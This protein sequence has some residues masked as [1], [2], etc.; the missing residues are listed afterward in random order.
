MNRRV[1]QFQNPI[2]LLNKLCII[3]PCMKT[4]SYFFVILFLWC[5]ALPAL[6]QTHT[7]R[8]IS[9][10]SKT[11]A[12]YEYLPEGYDSTG[13]ATYPLILF[14]TGIGEFGSGSSTQLPNVL[15]NGIPKLIKE[16]TFPKSF[17]VGGQVFR[18]I[19]ITPQFIKS[20]RPEAEDM[21]TVLDY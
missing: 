6:A 5:T 12:Y 13:T 14:M 7:P 2:L 15:K 18:F 9:M 10:M 19:V 1:K 21:N 17:T 16:G 3:Q 8:Y 20:P 11:K 4:A